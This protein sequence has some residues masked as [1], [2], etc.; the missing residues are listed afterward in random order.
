MS[1]ATNDSTVTP[2]P[3]PAPT[4]TLPPTATPSLTLPPTHTPSS[5]AT[6]TATATPLLIPVFVLASAVLLWVLFQSYSLFNE[7]QALLAAAAQ[8]APQAETATKVRASIDSIA[9]GVKRLADGGNANARVIVDELARRG[10][11]INPNSAPTGSA[12]K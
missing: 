10:V 6:A 2:A 4:P 5:T 8:L 7:R 1:E 3:A 12:T 11:T 9:A